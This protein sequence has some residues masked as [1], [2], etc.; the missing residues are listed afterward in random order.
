MPVAVV[1]AETSVGAV[2]AEM[3]AAVRGM[4]Y[5]EAADVVKAAR[6]CMHHRAS[7]LDSAHSVLLYH[8]CYSYVA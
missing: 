6:R 1:V 2:A 7:I 8:P 5:A 4:A 3:R